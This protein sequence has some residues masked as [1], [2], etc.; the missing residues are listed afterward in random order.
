MKNLTRIVF[1]ALAIVLVATVAV[2]TPRTLHAAT[3]LVVTLVQDYDNAGRHPFVADCNIDLVDTASAS[4]TATT[5][6]AGDEYV[7]QTETFYGQVA[8]KNTTVAYDLRVTTAGEVMDAGFGVANDVGFSQ[9]SYAET[10]TTYPWILY[11]DTGTPIMCRAHT[12]RENTANT[13][14]D[15]YKATCVIEGYYVGPL[16]I[17]SS[18]VTP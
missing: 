5:V 11:A 3:A 1:V 2:L 13:G 17:G 15:I 9:P 18:T 10:Y 8:P 6:P 4:C 12:A 7:I 14:L 16:I